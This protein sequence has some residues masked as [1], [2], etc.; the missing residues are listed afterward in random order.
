M[1]IISLNN[2]NWI[3][4]LQWRRCS[5]YEA[6]S[7]LVNI[8]QMNVKFQRVNFLITPTQALSFCHL[9][10]HRLSHS[11]AHSSRPIDVSPLSAGSKLSAV[12]P[13]ER[14]TYRLSA[15]QG[16]PDSGPSNPPPPTPKAQSR[17]LPPTHLR[18][19]VTIRI[20]VFWHYTGVFKNICNLTV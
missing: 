1:A 13:A 19:N 5:L 18:L 3:V 8:I 2:V 12:E 11:V 9:L 17:S 15:C 6:W 14:Y 7:E 20:A 16:W 4:F 10:D